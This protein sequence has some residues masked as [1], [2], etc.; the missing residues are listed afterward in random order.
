MIREILL[1]AKNKL[2]SANINEIDGEIL[3]AHHLGISRMDLHNPIALESALNKIELQAIKEL[4]FNDIN[5]RISNV[6][7]QYLTGVAYFRDLELRVGPGVLIPRPETESLVSFILEEISEKKEETS[8]IDLGSG[9]GAIAIALATENPLIRAI[10][11]EKSSEALAW[12]KENVAKYS[13]D[14]RVVH[15]DV[16]DVLID[17]KSDYVIANPPYL[18]NSFTLPKEVLEHEPAEALFGGHDGMDIPKIFIDAAA[19]LLK[20]GGGLVIE[21]EESQGEKIASAMAQ[22]FELIELHYDLNHRPR[23]TTGKRRS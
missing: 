1:E 23:W 4:F 18:P 14:L 16:S 21:H 20:P 22:D 11:V 15:G 3:L 12:L 6:P 13:P 10:A 19:R 9:S 7:V 2:T 17:V 8:V 5:Q